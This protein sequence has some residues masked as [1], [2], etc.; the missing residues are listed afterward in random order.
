MRAE[1][2]QIGDAIDRQRLRA[3]GHGQSLEQAARLAAALRV[4]QRARSA[5]YLYIARD[6]ERRRARLQPRPLRSAAQRPRGAHA[7]GRFSTSTPRSASATP[8]SAQSLR[9]RSA[10]RC[11]SGCR[12]AT[13]TCAPMSSA[14]RSAACSRRNN[15]IADRLKHVIEP[16]FSVQRDHQ[17]RRIRT[18]SSE[19]AAS[20]DFIVGGVTRISYGLTNRLLVRKASADPATR[21]GGSRSAPRELLSVG[22]TQSYYTDARASQF[23]AATNRASCAEADAEPLLAGRVDVRAPSPTAF[24]TATLAHGVRPARTARCE[25]STPAA[26]SNYRTQVNCGRLEPRELRAVLSTGDADAFNA[27]TTLNFAEGR[28][29]GTYALDWDISARLHHPAALDRLLQRAVLRHRGRVPAVQVPDRRS[30]AGFPQDRRFNLVVHAR[31]HRHV[32]E[33]LRRLRRRALLS[34]SSAVRVTTWV[35]SACRAR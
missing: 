17:L 22:I 32:L 2:F 19:S 29:G 24:T 25:P 11:R 3:V 6:R 4:G 20:Y 35:R 1:L 31:R 7:T 12:G 33:L 8:T 15:A 9:R 23:D 10:C 28:T 34:A 14:R 21:R 26:S 27:S 18:A 16:T 5:R 13:S 30:S